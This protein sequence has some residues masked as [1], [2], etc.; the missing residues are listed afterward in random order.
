M[1]INWKVRLKNPMV[2]IT[3]FPTIVALIYAVLAVFGVVPSITKETVLDVFYAAV[4]A[5]A[6]LGIIVDPTTKV[7]SDSDRA[8]NYIKPSGGEE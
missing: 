5:L 7:V 1:K 4:A 8:M 6:T 3:A 2:W